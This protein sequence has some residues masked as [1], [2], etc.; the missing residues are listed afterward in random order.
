[1]S[2]LLAHTCAD[3]AVVV[4]V[5]RCDGVRAVTLRYS[6][7]CTDNEIVTRSDVALLLLVPW[8]FQRCRCWCWRRALY[9]PSASAIIY[10]VVTGHVAR[11]ICVRV[12]PAF[13][14]LI[15]VNALAQ[16][17][18]HGSIIQPPQTPRMHLPNVVGLVTAII[19]LVHA[20]AERDSKDLHA[21]SRRVQT[22]A[23]TVACA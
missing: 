12:I 21:N 18:R 19:K 20:N 8:R 23:T 7:S 3:A 14:A 22:I 17:E 9:K 6:V 13:R 15:V 16:Q 5:L 11:T 2:L 1:M 10:V 4:V